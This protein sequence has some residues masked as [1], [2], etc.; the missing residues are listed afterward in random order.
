MTRLR[1]RAAKFGGRF[2]WEEWKGY[3]D[4]GRR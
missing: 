2:D 4:A 3:R 1:D